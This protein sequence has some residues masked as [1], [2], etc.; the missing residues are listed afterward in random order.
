MPGLRA[1]DTTNGAPPGGNH[2]ATRRRRVLEGQRCRLPSYFRDKVSSTRFSVADGR[3]A[4]VAASS[5]GR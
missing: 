1:P 5:E 3:M 2:R 4:C